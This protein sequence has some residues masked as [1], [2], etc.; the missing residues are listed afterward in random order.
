[1]IADYEER[2]KISLRDGLS[3]TE[4]LLVNDTVCLDAGFV[5][6]A[7]SLREQVKVK[8]LAEIVAEAM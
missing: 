5:S 6:G 2:A 8:D 1:M 4:A 3:G 7:L